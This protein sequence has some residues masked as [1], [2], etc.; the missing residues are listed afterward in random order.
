M[1]AAHVLEARDL[2]VTRGSVVLVRVEHFAVDAGEVHVILGPNGAGKSALLRALNGLEPLSGTLLFRGEPVLSERDRRRLRLSTA[3][4]F[5]RPLLLATTVRAN[6]ESGLRLRGVG[7]AEARARA[8]GA[9]ELMGVAHLAARRRDGLSGGEAQ[10]VSIARA[11]A[12]DPELLFLDEPMAALDPPTRRGLFRDLELIVKDRALTVV[13]VTHDREEALMVADAATFLAAGRVVQQGTGDDVFNQPASDEVAEYLGVDVWLRGEVTDGQDG[14]A[15]FVAEGGGALACAD[16]ARGP[17]FASVHPED[18]TLS[19]LEPAAGATSA[20]NVLPATIRYIRPRG[21]LRV[22][23]LDWAGQRLQ[24]LVTQAAADELGLAV[25][26][27]VY[28][29][30]KAAAVHVTP[31]GGGPGGS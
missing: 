15:R 29:V 23:V 1:P 21:R 5:Q 4:V 7:H 20:R 3:A 26:M 11:L 22:V 28:A 24:A 18:V 10:R 16:G 27:M 9:L 19:L 25:G 14:G 2:V 13:W 8:A 12:S 6:V 30:V 31:R 17:A